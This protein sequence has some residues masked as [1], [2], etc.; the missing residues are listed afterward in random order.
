M[1]GSG[2]RA[3]IY[4]MSATSAI[5]ATWEE[6]WQSLLAARPLPASSRELCPAALIDITVAGIPG[7][8]RDVASDATG[9]ATRLLQNTL[10]MLPR[11]SG[12]ARRIYGGSN[13]GESDLLDIAIPDLSPAQRVS[14]TADVMPALIHPIGHWVYSACSS[15]SHALIMAIL[16][17]AE[18]HAEPV[19][20]AAVDALSAVEILGFARLGAISGEACRPFAT[21]RDGLLIGEGCAALEIG[22]SAEAAIGEIMGFG[23]SADA[24]HP[25]DPDPAGE[26]VERAIRSALDD[27]GISPSEVAAI[28]AHGTATPKN[29]AAEL[30]AIRRVF[31]AVCPPISSLKASL[32]HTMGAA[33]LFNVLAAVS[34]SRSAMVAPIGGGSVMEDGDFVTGT[35]RPIPPGGAILCLASGFGGNNV[36]ILARGVAG[37]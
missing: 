33:G 11:R 28:F 8:R 21:D 22:A 18:G 9:A 15:G 4:A 26:G 13:H 5:G 32:G 14:L 31:G 12:P 25:T 29:D 20:V 1:K 27:A 17:I 23:I 10:A 37:A 19:I 30:A 16:D 7:L 3:Y 35:P 34:A 2:S 24:H 6:S 36:A